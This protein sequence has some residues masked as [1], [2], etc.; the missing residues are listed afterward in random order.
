[1]TVTAITPPKNRSAET[2]RM[3]IHLVDALKRD[4]YD[5]SVEINE[6][7]MPVISIIQAM[8]TSL[9]KISF[10]LELGD[11]VGQHGEQHEQ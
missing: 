8:D 4:G 10:E 11:I 9:E 7:G 6:A 5:C 2:R 1:M 3:A